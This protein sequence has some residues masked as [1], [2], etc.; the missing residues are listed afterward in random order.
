MSTP[1]LEDIGLKL[2]KEEATTLAAVTGIYGFENAD[3]AIYSN[4]CVQISGFL[5]ML[6]LFLMFRKKAP[7]VYYPNIRNKPQHPCYQENPGFISWL[8]KLIIVNDTSTLSMIGLDGFMF[9]QTIKL[10]YRICFIVSIMCLPL[11]IYNFTVPAVGKR[12][13]QFFT[14]F[15]TWNLK[16][17]SLFWAILLISYISSIIIFYIIFIYYKRY[18]TLRQLYLASPAT[19]TSVPQM[20]KISAEL[21]SNRNSVD[22]INVSS[23]TVFINRL[24][25]EISNDEELMEY[26]KSLGLGEIESVSLVRDTYK[27][28]K[29]YEKRDAIIQDIEK[30]IASA[31]NKLKDKYNSKEQDIVESFGDLASNDLEKSATIIFNKNKIPLS[32]RTKLLNTFMNNGDLFLSK[33]WLNKAILGIHLD[34]LKEVN[35]EILDEKKYIEGNTSENS[36]IDIPTADETL[37][38]ESDVR[39]D[40][41]FFSIRQIL[42]LK[43]NKDYFEIELPV[44]KKKGFVTFKNQKTCGI[45]KQTKLGSKAFSSNVDSAPPP[46]DVLWRNITKSEISSFF[47]SIV[48][49]GLFVLLNIAFLYVVI[50]I[51]ESL[52]VENNSK[53]YIFRLIFGQNAKFVSGLYQGMLAPFIYNI[54][55]YFVPIFLKA[56][57]HMEDTYSYTGVQSKLMYRLSLFLFFNG[58]LATFVSSLLL[59][60]FTK[61]KSQSIG[62][63]RLI[64]ES[65]NAIIESSVFFLNTIVQRMCIGS[66]MVILKPAAFAYNFLIAPIALRTRRQEQEREFSPPIDFGNHVPNLLLIMPMALT[67]SCICPFIV[68]AA[69]LFYWFSYLVYKNELLYATRNDYE[70]GGYY[71]KPSVRFIM[72]SVVAFQISTA[73][74]TFSSGNMLVS[75]L[76]LPLIFMSVICLQGIEQIFD[77]SSDNFPMN[78]P[79]EKFLD[80]FTKKV[81]EER[82]K[83]LNDWKEI[84]EEEDMDV[85]PVSEFGIEDKRLN[86]SESYYNDP[87]MLESIGTI[88]LPRNFFYVIQ[89][90]VSFD[91]K[92]VC[93]LNK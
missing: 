54:L 3:T 86:R 53:N 44:N 26:M 80:F 79:E 8:Y 18:V 89:F 48:S 19:M 25:S 87:N 38:T 30:E 27:L 5:I 40:V 83:L 59:S 65:S 66:A 46:Y 49:T 85:I 71:W 16:D 51:I 17:P 60:V 67:Y 50:M 20:K 73:T 62:M 31:Y 32:E 7:W 45:I 43:K 6:S 76:F 12:S 91:K 9:L 36:T 64:S 4:T 14:R 28:Q 42:N 15:T 88:I 22:Y 37:F 24:P 1:S 13:E 56:L 23:R 82:F 78:T 21:G 35:N 29:L 52:Q 2:N 57:I 33:T 34:N 61:F 41:S 84:S 72:L 55:L 93:R 47:L 11:L 69:F 68:I 81:M 70:S 63:N 90:I 92:N 75:I 74:I 10:L 77:K 39:H 58:F